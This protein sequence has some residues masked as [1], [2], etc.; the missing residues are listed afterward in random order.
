MLAHREGQAP[1]APWICIKYDPAKGV[2]DPEY[3]PPARGPEGDP[4]PEPEPEPLQPVEN[5]PSP[6]PKPGEGSVPPSP[7]TPN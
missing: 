7:V 3:K 1:A 2:D 4:D 5:D 6:G